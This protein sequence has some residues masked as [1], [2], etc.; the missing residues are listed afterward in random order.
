MS[1]K[2]EVYDLNENLIE[3]KERN[4]FYKEIKKRVSKNRKDNKTGQT[5]SAFIDEFSGKNCVT[6]KKFI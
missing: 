4:K 1:E 6:K 5:S 2:L 3:V